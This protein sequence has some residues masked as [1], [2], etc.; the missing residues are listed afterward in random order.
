[1]ALFS[2]LAVLAWVQWHES[3]RSRWVLISSGCYLLAVLSKETAVLLPSLLLVTPSYRA[4]LTRRSITAVLLMVAGAAVVFGVRMRVGA[5]MPGTLDS[6]YGLIQPAVRW[7]RNLEN[8]LGRVFPSALGLLAIAGIPAWLHQRRTG[9]GWD[10]RNLRDLVVFAIAWFVSSFSRFFL[11]FAERTVF[12]SAGSGMSACWPISRR[13]VVNA[14][15]S[16]RLAVISVGV[17]ILAFG[18]YSCPAAARCTT[19]CNSLR[20]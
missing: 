19:T 5:M 8:Y 20:R 3:Q 17:Y 2:V 9:T 18:G 11:S 1:M 6:H 16:G 7:A 10:R 14:R 13:H 15:A 12:I 4:A